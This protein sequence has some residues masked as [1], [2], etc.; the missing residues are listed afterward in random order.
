MS[1]QGALFQP[2]MASVASGAILG[3]DPGT[4]CGW[5][6]RHGEGR[7]DSGVWNLAPKRFEGGGMR[8][9][10]L[11]THLRELLGASRPA[12]LAYEEVRR[13]AGTTAAHIYGGIV[14]VIQEECEA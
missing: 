11:R 3:I 10:R 8:W 14:A 5:A 13:H 12:I 6:L 1:A 9:V 7:V 4:H 2:V